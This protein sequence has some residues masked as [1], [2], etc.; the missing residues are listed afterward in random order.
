MAKQRPWMADILRLLE[1]RGY[2]SAELAE[3]LGQSHRYGPDAREVTL[4]LRRD[5]RFRVICETGAASL[6]RN[7][8]HTLPVFGLASA[9]Y[10]LEHPFE[11]N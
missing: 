10:R 1:A 7:R 9:N 5:S 11:R 8:S 6:L 3:I 2:T 4:V